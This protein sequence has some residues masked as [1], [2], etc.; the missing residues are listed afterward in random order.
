MTCTLMMGA[1]TNSSCR[2]SHMFHSSIETLHNYH[3]DKLIKKKGKQNASPEFS[4]GQLVGHIP[5]I[6]H[7]AGLFDQV[8]GTAT[9]DL[10]HEHWLSNVVTLRREL[11]V[12]IE[13]FHLYC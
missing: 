4:N 10:T 13:G 9:I 5:R 1:H 7:V 11:D 3:S 6:R 12:T 2:L 8:V